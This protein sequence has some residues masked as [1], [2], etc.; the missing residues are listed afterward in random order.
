M[1]GLTLHFML[2][3]RVLGRWQSTPEAAPFDPFEPADV[4]AFLHG[5]VGPD[6]GYLPGGCRVLS[7]L[8]HRVRTGQLTERLIGSA[9]TP[10]ERAFAWGWL[11]HVLADRLVHPWIG[12]GV[13]ELTLGSRDTFVAGA[14]DLQSHLRVEIGVDCWYAAREV[15][16][17]S[18][19]LRPA[20][21]EMSINFLSH[22]YAATYGFVPT[23][24][25]LLSS[26]VGVARRVG[27]ALS[28]IHVV[29]ALADRVSG[30]RKL[31]GLGWALS[32][33]RK[34]GL[35]SATSVA[36]LSPVSPSAWLLD[37]IETVVPQ[38]TE[39]FMAV[40]RNG[41]TD[42]GDFDLDTGQQLT[43]TPPD[44]RRGRVAVVT[45]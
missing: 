3:H 44:V 24:K 15:G 4:N 28:S 6:F 30:P 45:P 31:P 34:A 12:R 43:R 33:A 39:L 19:R 42:I 40:Y 21:D 17:R 7:D 29:A 35:L 32:A 11:T 13:G 41:G 38:H 37:A 5:S 2:A 20:F 8:A 9:R 14:A 36:Y 10:V 23:R 18:V 1:P 26:H 25:S 27:Q 22:A 16:A